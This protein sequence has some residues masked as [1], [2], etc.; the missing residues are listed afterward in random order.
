[1][2]YTAAPSTC[3]TGEKPTDLIAANSSEV[4]AEPQ[5][6]LARISRIRAS[7]AGGSS[8]DTPPAYSVLGVP[9]LIAAL[10]GFQS[11]RGFFAGGIGTEPVLSR[12]VAV[13]RLDGVMPEAVPP[14]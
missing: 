14:S 8:S 4:S 9:F 10:D 13:I 1:M 6:P 3:P 7:A 11:A 5:V 2:L 12:A